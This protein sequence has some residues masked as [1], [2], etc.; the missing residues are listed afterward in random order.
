M[1]QDW[2]LTPAAA[3]PRKG[4]GLII[5]GI[6]LLLVG[7]VMVVAGVIGAIS[8]TAGLVSGFGSPVATPGTIVR[9]LDGST[10]YVVYELVPFSGAS[11]NLGP[12]DVEVTGPDGAVP[13]G[14][15]PSSPAPSGPASSSPAPAGPASVEPV[16][17]TAAPASAAPA[18]LPASG[19]VPRRRRRRGR[20]TAE[21]RHEQR[22]HWRL[23]L[24]RGARRRLCARLPRVLHRMRL[25]HL[26]EC[27]QAHRQLS[28]ELRLL[29][30]RLQVRQQLSTVSG[31]LARLKPQPHGQ[32]E[33]QDPA[34]SRARRDICP[35][36]L[37]AQRAARY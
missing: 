15:A 25:D 34:G 1:S 18:P 3:P 36:C 7:V 9:E 5:T 11:A 32:I 10:T 26:L 16:D 2:S 37:R 21:P 8:A 33:V 14:P 22:G 19:R 12:G 13:G 27:A 20:G 30:P 4:K 29:V 31:H 23:T 24:G 17:P 6:V 35:N 28:H